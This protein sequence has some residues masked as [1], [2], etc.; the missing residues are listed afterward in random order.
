MFPLAFAFRFREFSFDSTQKCH[1]G[2]EHV[3]LALTP[4]AVRVQKSLRDRPGPA[5][6]VAG[7]RPPGAAGSPLNPQSVKTE[8]R[9]AAGGRVGDAEL[10]KLQKWDCWSAPAKRPERG[11]A[12][13]RRRPAGA[14]RRV[15]PHATTCA[16]HGSRAVKRISFGRRLRVGQHAAAAQPGRAVGTP[17]PRPNLRIRRLPQSTAP[18][19]GSPVTA[20]SDASESAPPSQPAAK[21]PGTVPIGEH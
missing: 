8:R 18:A 7:R 17:G 14:A 19:A 13:L 9:P 16:N 11:Q 15:R 10:E 4:A 5:T 12:L 21:P 20:D 1:M 6:A 2:A 3:R